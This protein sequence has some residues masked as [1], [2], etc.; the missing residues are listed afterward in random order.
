MDII[1]SINIMIKLMLMELKYFNHKYANLGSF[2][3]IFITKLSSLES[4]KIEI[5]SRKMYLLYFSKIGTI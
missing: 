2:F 5:E 3:I 1:K 4:S